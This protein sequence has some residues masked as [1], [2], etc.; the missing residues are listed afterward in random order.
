MKGEII[1]AN[2]QL[3]KNIEEL[4]VY[5]NKLMNE[6][7][8]LVDPTEIEEVEMRLKHATEIRNRLSENKV[9]ESYTK[10]IISGAIGLTGMVLVLKH[11]R[12]EVITSKAFSMA[13][14]MFRGQ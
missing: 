10:E 13:T 4:D 7:M 1:M 9:R 5:I 6:L 12:A 3:V 14:K 2:K 11:E 8:V